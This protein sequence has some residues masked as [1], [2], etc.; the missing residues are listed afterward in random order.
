MVIAAL[1]QNSGGGTPTRQVRS[2]DSWYCPGLSITAPQPTVC[3]L[4]SAVAGRSERKANAK[5][6]QIKFLR[7][8]RA[9]SM[10]ENLSLGQLKQSQVQ[11]NL[12]CYSPLL[13]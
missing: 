12:S 3:T 8:T 7:L 5:A 9:S 6:A 2:P 13:L 1:S 10:P 11:E 4:A